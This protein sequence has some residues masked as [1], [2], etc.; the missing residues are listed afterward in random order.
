LVVLVES[1]GSELTSKV[2]LITIERII[3][4]ESVIICQSCLGT[5]TRS[6]SLLVRQ[7]TW[8]SLIQ[9]S[10]VVIIA[11]GPQVIAIELCGGGGND[12]QEDNLQNSS[13]N[14]TDLVNE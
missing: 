14:L 5:K 6:T 11:G 3:L 1:S 13:L 10:L 12:C 2:I 4:V 9:I 7:K 8:S